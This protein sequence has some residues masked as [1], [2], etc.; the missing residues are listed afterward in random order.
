[1][2]RFLATIIILAAACAGLSYLGASD[3]SPTGN[4]AGRKAEKPAAE[5]EARKS[6]WLAHNVYFSLKD[7]SETAKQQLVADSHKYLSPI[8]GTVFY[9][10]GT[11]SDADSE[12]NDRDFDV[13]LHVVFKDKS[14][15]QKYLVH[16]KHLEYVEKHKPNWKRVRVFDS[17]VLGGK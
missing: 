9:A 10:A 1:M 12:L 17:D 6:S 2:K 13:A 14:A 4:A 8:P 15:M 11:L 16:P 7:N 5:N 3:L